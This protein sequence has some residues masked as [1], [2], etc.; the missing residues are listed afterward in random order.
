[1]RRRGQDLRYDF[2][3]SYGA[4]VR[5]YHVERDRAFDLLEDALQKLT[6]GDQRFSSIP[7]PV[8]G[9]CELALW[10]AHGACSFLRR[11]RL[12]VL[13]NA[14]VVFELADGAEAQ[15]SGGDGRL[16]V[17][18]RQSPT[19][20]VRNRKAFPKLDREPADSALDR[21]GNAVFSKLISGDSENAVSATCRRHQRVSNAPRA[22]HLD[23]HWGSR[24]FE[25][26]MKRHLPLSCRLEASMA[27]PGANVA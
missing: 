24:Q 12:E 7:G 27:P 23:V 6:A 25:Y 26:P 16:S 15:R 18:L 5:I 13:R 10:P 1:M 3:R 22:E 4:I 9:W 17:Y 14:H 11:K 21:G 2:T 20:K 8:R 19:L